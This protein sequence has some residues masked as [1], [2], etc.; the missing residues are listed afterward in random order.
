MV[1]SN[2]I[3]ISSLTEA[4][5]PM[6][7][8]DYQKLIALE[9]CLNSK[10]GDI[11]YIECKG[12]IANSDSIIET[13][14]H[15]GPIYLTDSTI[16]FWKTLMN[17]INDK[18][19][20]TPNEKLRCVELIKNKSYKSIEKYVNH[21]FSFDSSYSESDLV[22]I[23]KKLEIHSSQPNIFEKWNEI[24]A[25]FVFIPE[26]Y[27]NDLLIYLFGY[28]SDRLI[29]DSN[30]WRIVF[31]DFERDYQAITRKYSNDKIPFPEEPADIQYDDSINYF[32][33]EQL[34]KINLD[35]EVAQ[36]VID[37]LK[38]DIVS[39]KLI[40][41]G[42]SG[43]NIAINDFETELCEKMKSTKIVH[44]LDL[45]QQKIPFDES[46][47]PSQKLYYSCRRFDKLLI[48]GIQDIK[49]YYQYGKMH[50]IVEE[51]HFE[52]EFSGEYYE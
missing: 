48:D 13:K 24:K 49:I 33:I 35:R 18:N 26:K 11:I 15:C 1:E 52:W 36:A 40:E 4:T 32:F 22:D 44:A 3:P 41:Y 37:F 5:K 23:L 10:S 46:T 14:H 29:K 21:I 6:L 43:T 38:G 34:R 39:M 45:L 20:K 8:F 50:K 27:R 30:Y 31:D 7:G 9:C 47:I 12:D 16:E 51:K 28:V 2:I 42:G 17:F 25:R 19:K